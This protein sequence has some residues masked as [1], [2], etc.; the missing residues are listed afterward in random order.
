MNSISIAQP[1]IGRREMN[2][3]A[4]VMRTKHLAQGPKVAEFEKEFADYIGVTHAVAVSS[5]TAALQTSL[6]AM[7]IGPGDE[8]ITSSF[9]F[10]A[11]ANSI[12]YTGA[13]PVFADISIDDFNIR[14][15]EIEAR[16]TPRTKAIMPVHLFGQ[17]AEMD[18]IKDIADRN[19][20]K[21]VEDACQAHGASYKGCAAGSFYAGCFSFYS[22]KNMTTGEGG[23]VTTDDEALADMIRLIRN[24]GMAVRYQHE[25]LGF[26]F[27]MTDMAAAIGIEQLKKLTAANELRFQNAMFLNES[28]NGIPGLVTPMISRDRTHVFH[29]YTV[30]ITNACRRGR[31]ELAAGLAA[32]GIGTGVYYPVPIHQQEVYRDL[33][34]DGKLPVTETAAN[35]VLSLPVHPNVSDEDLA[36]IGDSIRELLYA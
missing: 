8:V 13:K 19:G 17:M 6:L 29:Q 26:N 2:A 14:S 35:E 24:Q 7:G 28:L 27:R 9:S 1:D 25:T 10:I 21:V 5:G 31:D 3:V 12:T 20:L 16:I 22:T 18:A 32:K 4:D 11:S 23:M 33:G 34:Y 15:D 30:R 36:F